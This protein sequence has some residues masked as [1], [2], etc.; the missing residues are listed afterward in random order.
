M[1]YNHDE[2]D[3]LRACNINP[4]IYI[5]TIHDMLILTQTS[6]PMSKGIEVIEELV[7]NNPHESAFH[8]AQS[9]C[10]ASHCIALLA[11][12]IKTLDDRLSMTAGTNPAMNEEY[13]ALK[14][15]MKHMN[16]KLEMILVTDKSTTITFN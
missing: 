8:I 5:N 6:N 15:D 10:Q 16:A 1:T 3:I 11:D 4:T 9:F 14:K 2:K 7:R 13:N 12:I